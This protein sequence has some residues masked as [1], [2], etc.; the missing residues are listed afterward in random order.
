MKCLEKKPE[1]RFA[2]VR[3]LHEALTDTESDDIWNADSAADWWKHH[4]CPDKKRLDAEV[5]EF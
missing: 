3:L 2:N 4:G 5:L 1:N